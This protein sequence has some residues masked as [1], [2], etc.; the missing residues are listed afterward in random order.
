MF[1][2]GLLACCWSTL[3]VVM[4]GFVGLLSLLLLICFEV[5]EE[6]HERADQW[7]LYS[8]SLVTIM[9][10]A[11]PGVIP[12]TKSTFAW[13]KSHALAVSRADGQQDSLQ[14]QL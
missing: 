1:L 3:L 14:V 6:S 13:L 5:I 4:V 8:L 11:C 2:W 12:N 9:L 7:Y 10:I